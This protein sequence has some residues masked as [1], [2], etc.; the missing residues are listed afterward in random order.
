VVHDR[1]G[2]TV[3]QVSG[4]GE[5]PVLKRADLLHCPSVRTRRKERPSNSSEAMPKQFAVISSEIRK[6]A[7]GDSAASG[8]SESQADANNQRTPSQGRRYVSFKPRKPAGQLG[9]VT[10]IPGSAFVSNRRMSDEQV[11]GLRSAVDALRI[12][13]GRRG[14]YP[15]SC[16]RIRER[17][18]RRR[19]SGRC[20]A[21][22]P[23]S[24]A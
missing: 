8:G 13:I 24:R 11:S 14:A 3:S 2:S 7:P 23:C 4:E 12:S 17:P 21:C 19:S 16:I 9:R 22:T 20:C 5:R 6:L 18:S 10:A 15:R 1:S